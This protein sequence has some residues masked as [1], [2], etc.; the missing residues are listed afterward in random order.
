MKQPKPSPEQLKAMV[1]EYHA[2]RNAALKD[3]HKRAHAA[4]LQRKMELAKKKAM[5]EQQDLMKE[6]LDEHNPS[7]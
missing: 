1:K 2:Q 3:R 7:R 6:I 4:L 5:K